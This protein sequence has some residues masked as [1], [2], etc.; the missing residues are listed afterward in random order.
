MQDNDHETSLQS[1]VLYPHKEST[2]VPIIKLHPC[3][4]AVRNEDLHYLQK[5][6]LPKLQTAQY[7]V[8]ACMDELRVD[9]MQGSGFTSTREGTRAG[10]RPASNV[11]F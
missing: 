3:L 6:Q 2:G 9:I 11:W 10:F 5:D 7:F 4:Y 8:I 1:E